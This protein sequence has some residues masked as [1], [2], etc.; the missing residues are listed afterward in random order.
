M[1]SHLTLH[2]LLHHV[3][4]FSLALLSHISSNTISYLEESTIV[5]YLFYDSNYRTGPPLTFWKTV[6]ASINVKSWV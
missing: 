6:Y 4:V 1:S 2:S 3:M 5:F